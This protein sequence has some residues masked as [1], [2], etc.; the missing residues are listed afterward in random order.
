LAAKKERFLYRHE[1]PDAEDPEPGEASLGDFPLTA[2]FFLFS[3]KFFR[4]LS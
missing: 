2:Y 1:S 4:I 3:L